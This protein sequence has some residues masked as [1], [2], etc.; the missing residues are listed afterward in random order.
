MPSSNF[1]MQVSVPGNFDRWRVKC[2]FEYY[3][4]TPIKRRFIERYVF[5][6]KFISK[7]HSPLNNAIFR[8][9]LWCFTRFPEPISL[10]GTVT[11]GYIT[12]QVDYVTAP[13][14]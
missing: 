2:G 9:V 11:S 5:T 12:N 14:K 4:H 1:V 7:P 13:N 6:G 10:H 8:A 3:K